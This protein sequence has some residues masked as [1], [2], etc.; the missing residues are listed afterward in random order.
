LARNTA[1]SWRVVRMGEESIE[2]CGGTHLHRTAQVGLSS[3][4]ANPAS[5]RDCA[6]SR[7]HRQIGSPGTCTIWRTKL[8]NT[9]DAS[10]WHLPRLSQPPRGLFRPAREAQRRDRPAEVKER[11]RCRGDLAESAQEANG[12]KFR[13]GVGPTVDVPT[14]QKLADSITDKLVSGV[15][16]LAGVSDGKCCSWEK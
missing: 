9:A 2:L 3:S 8:R 1:M 15:V 5:A 12:V 16:I 10:A 14:L 7:R 13:H 6:E 4:R 11:S